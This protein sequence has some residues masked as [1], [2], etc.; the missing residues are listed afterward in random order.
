M[1]GTCRWLAVRRRSGLGLREVCGDEANSEKA[2][3]LLE[4]GLA[5]CRMI[6]ATLNWE[7]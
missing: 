1:D 6:L 3:D 7:A 2:D 4:K 5:Q